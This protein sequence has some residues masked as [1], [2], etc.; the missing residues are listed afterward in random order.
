MNVLDLPGPEFLGFYCVLLAG[1]V[2]IGIALRSFLRGP[3]DVPPSLGTLD[4][5]EVAYLVR[6]PR[7]VADA[8]LTSMFHA[9]KIKVRTSGAVQLSDTE[10]LPPKGKSIET[11]LFAF[12]AE[13]G[14]TVSAIRWRC[15][16]YSEPIANNLR[17]LG[18][19]PTE[20]SMWQVR[21]VPA[22]LTGAV[23]LLGIAK[24]MVG[25]ARNR[26]VGF[27]VILCLITVAI[28]IGFMSMPIYCTRAG[29]RVLDRLRSAN[30]ALAVN[31]A[32]APERLPHYEL[33]MAVALFGPTALTGSE[34]AQFRAILWPPRSSGSCSGGHGC[35]GGGCGGGG[36]G[37]GG[38]GGCGGG[39]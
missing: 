21:F 20:S 15:Q 27:L 38:C 5:Y 35:G 13:G 17:S 8:A 19:A 24:I 37:G 16:S 39:H 10:L 25:L 4:A 34:L 31:A 30:Q 12:I 7:M 14:A 32:S 6:G 28:A 26:P 9:G 2:I 29:G 36:G 18:L 11:Q 3:G 22:M 23:L 1:I 33:A